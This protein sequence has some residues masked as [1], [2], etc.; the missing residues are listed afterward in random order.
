MFFSGWFGN[1]ATAFSNTAFWFVTIASLLVCASVWC[2][3]FQGSTKRWKCQLS[4]QASSFWFV[5]EV[6]EGEETL[7][8]VGGVLKPEEGGQQTCD[9]LVLPAMFARHVRHCFLP[10]QWL[11]KEVISSRSV[12]P[13]RTSHADPR[14]LV[15][16]FSGERC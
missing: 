15:P 16:C 13:P 14:S 3:Q 5:L 9:R 8:L 7:H 12:L 1:K 6:H 11:T 4:Y 2:L 10:P